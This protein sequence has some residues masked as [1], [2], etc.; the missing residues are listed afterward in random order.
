MQPL[1]AQQ[2]V[3]TQEPMFDPEAPMADMPDFGVEWPDLE[4]MPE[5][6]EDEALETPGAPGTSEVPAAV[7]IAGERRYGV[8]VDGLDKIESHL[9]HARFKELS[10]LEQGK[11]KPANAAQIDRRAREDEE[12]LETLMRSSGYYDARVDTKVEVEANGHVLV[13]LTVEPGEVYRFTDVD[14]R[15]IDQAGDKAEA[16]RDAFKVTENDPVDADKVLAGEAALRQKI[17]R[18]GFPFAKVSE[19]EVVVD[20]EDRT[21]T[22]VLNVEPG[23]PRKFGK[24]TVANDDVFSAR[25]IQ[26]IGR[27]K[28]GDPYD[29]AD[30]D[31]LRRA[32]IATGLV[33]S[34][35]VQPV[36]GATP[37]TVDVAVAIEPAPP[38]T[39]AGE[40]GYGTG[41]GARLEASWQHRNFL[42]PEG[43]VTVR[44]VVGTQEQLISVQFRRNNFMKRDRVLNAQVAAQHEER[45]AYEARTFTISGNIERQ[46][47]LVFQKKWTWSIG[48]EMLASDERDTV[49]PD[50]TPRRRTFFI[51]ALPGTLGYDSTD[52]LLDPTKGFRLSG[53]VSPE[54]SFQD[55]TFG[56]VKT[57]IDG[58]IYHPVSDRIVLAGRTRLGTIYGV[59]S[60]RIAPSRRFYA[61]GGGSVRGY[62]YQSIG[63]RDGN[64]DPIGGKSLIEFSLEARVRFGNFGVVPF[65]DAGNISTGTLPDI[66]KLRVGAGIGARYYTSFGPIRI[67]VGTPLNP[68]PGDAK[69]AVYVS[70]GQAF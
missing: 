9:M 3:Q 67:D 42:K 41:E 25:H 61:G 5:L 35:K 2:E 58:S 22:L 14:V 45:D 43:A 50:A 1:H 55:G 53:R 30:I 54:L 6:S 29:S 38:R 10:T 28:P 40:L 63:P 18:E 15:G 60:D 39:I 13:V 16:L 56:Y 46:S 68:Q 65:V 51:G 57:Q 7:D 8:R 49:G 12:L 33:S 4:K 11:G 27:F 20:H 31:D 64:N 52:N 59:E 24:V 62:G 32:L 48:A 47:N 69:I 34:A 36:P 19:P 70:L 44:G 23:A 37:D 66:G 26:R 21:A 17:G